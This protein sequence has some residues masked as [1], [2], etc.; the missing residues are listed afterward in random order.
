VAR[1]DSTTGGT[2]LV[3]SGFKG[4]A[5]IVHQ[6]VV[7]H[8]DLGFLAD[9]QA[10]GRNVNAF[11]GKSVNLLEKNLGV[12][13]YTVTDEAL[14]TLME[15]P[16][17]DEMQDTLLSFHNKSVTCVVSTLE[18]YNR[19]CLFGEHINDFALAFERTSRSQQINPLRPLKKIRLPAFDTLFKMVKYEIP[20]P[21]TIRVA[22]VDIER[23]F[24][25]LSPW[26]P[27][28]ERELVNEFIE[29]AGT[30]LDIKAYP[31]H[32][33]A[34]EALVKGKADILLATGYNPD[35]STTTP[36]LVKGPVYEKSPA[37]ML[38]HI[39]RFELRTPFE[40]CDQE[41]FVP[42][43]SGLVETFNELS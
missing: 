30:E 1:A 18:T 32:D 20:L 3:I 40:L 37:A 27:G 16:G 15:N 26:G 4:F 2:D 33:K 19:T 9:H 29:Y 10:L 25:K 42:A 21:N 38:H 28:F 23:V 24:P 41:V 11:F 22:A 5:A 7:R 12:E 13:Y 35:I 34:F 36:P 43:H 6:L 39:L 17:R 31:T 14:F 8:D